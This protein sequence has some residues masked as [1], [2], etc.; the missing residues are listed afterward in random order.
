MS[1]LFLDYRESRWQDVIFQPLL[2]IIQAL[3]FTSLAHIPS[4]SHSF[5]NTA[6]VY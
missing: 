6:I 5:Q 4:T 3:Y 2:F 1:A